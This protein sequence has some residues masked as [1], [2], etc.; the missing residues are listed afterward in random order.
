[1]SEFAKEEIKEYNLVTVPSKL[2]KFLGTKKMN[3]L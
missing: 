3:G 1:M 2:R